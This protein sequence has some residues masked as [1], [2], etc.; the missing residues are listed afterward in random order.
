MRNKKQKASNQRM[1]KDNLNL[2]AKC[3]GKCNA[4]GCRRINYNEQ[5]G[6]LSTIDNEMQ[7]VGSTGN[8]SSSQAVYRHNPSASSKETMYH[9][10]Q[11]ARGTK[12]QCTGWMH[13]TTYNVFLGLCY[14][15]RESEAASVM[16]NC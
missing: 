1:N 13:C 11:W 16:S 14:M 12:P 2:Q 3:K 5:D 15:D 7:H 8:S 6:K 10:T 4:S 9:L